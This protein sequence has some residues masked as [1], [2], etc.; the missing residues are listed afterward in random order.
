[1]EGMALKE[2]FWRRNFFRRKTDWV[3]SWYESGKCDVKSFEPFPT[4]WLEVEAVFH[5]N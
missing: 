1:M 4:D 3:E 5:L 2:R